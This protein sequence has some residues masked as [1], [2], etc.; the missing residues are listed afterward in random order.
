MSPDLAQAALDRARL[1][2]ILDTA[3]ADP[4]TWPG[5]VTALLDGGV[6]ILQV[7]AKEASREDILTWSRTVIP[8]AHQRGIP[9]I[10]NDF[11]DLV[12]PSGAAGVHIGQDDG[13]V[14]HARRIAGKPCLVGRSTHSLEQ[15][16]MAETEGADYIGF[17]P[18]FPTPTKPGRPAITPEA[19]PPM[20]RTIAIPAFCIGGITLERLPDLVQRGTRRAVIVSALLTAPDPAAYAKQTL[21]ALHPTPPL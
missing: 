6:G 4:A 3:Y 19:I 8:P 2:G 12:G 11:P 5:L 10:I 18:L 13:T 17:G 21:Q 20:A 7:R 15:A 16:Q 9:V 1:Y 14:D